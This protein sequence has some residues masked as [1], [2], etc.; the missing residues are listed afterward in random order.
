MKLRHVFTVNSIICLVYGAPFV[1]V[2]ALQ[3]SLYGTPPNGLGLLIGRL[4]GALP[5]GDAPG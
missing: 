1:A 4:F 5:R 3:L 2:P